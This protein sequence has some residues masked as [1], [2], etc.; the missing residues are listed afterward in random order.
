MSMTFRLTCLPWVFFI[1]DIIAMTSNDSV[2]L[3]AWI[4]GWQL[5]SSSFNEGNRHHFPTLEKNKN[6]KKKIM[7]TW[8]K[9]SKSWQW[10]IFLYCF[11]LDY[12]I[13]FLFQLFWLIIYQRGKKQAYVRQTSENSFGMTCVFS[14]SHFLYIHFQN[15]TCDFEGSG[16]FQGYRYQS[17]QMS[18]CCKVGWAQN[19]CERKAM[20]YNLD[21]GMVS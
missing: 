3:W 8:W 14:I 1:P 7:N 2:K 16:G 17:V 21:S 18:K 15:V 13:A 4:R 6:S 5:I 12:Y 9:H 10:I 20:K 11:S 19:S